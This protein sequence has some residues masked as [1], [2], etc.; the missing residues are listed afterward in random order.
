MTRNHLSIITTALLSVFLVACSPEPL[1]GESGAEPTSTESLLSEA[2]EEAAPSLAAC[3][4]TAVCG[5]CTTLRCDGTSTCSAA[6][7]PTGH[8]TC[9]GV[10]KA[11]QTCTYEGVTYNDG[12]Y[13]NDSSSIRCSAKSNGYCIGGPVAGMPC[14]ASG[15]CRVKCCNG[16]WGR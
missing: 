7:G 16:T 14:V 1:P 9:D 15:Q 3:T 8:A 5:T 10:V 2:T 11:C 4:A 12:Q 13:S 6:N